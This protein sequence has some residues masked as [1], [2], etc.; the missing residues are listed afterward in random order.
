[1]GPAVLQ[2]LIPILVPLGAFAL[3]AVLVGMGDLAKHRAREL[4]HQTIRFMVDKGQPVPPELLNDPAKA[5]P[6]GTDLSRGVKLISL[7]V[8][9]CAFLYLVSERAWSLGLV[10]I[11]LGIGYVVA[12][13]LSPPPSPEPAGTPR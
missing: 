2:S 9:I 7:G 12:H 8:G 3:V 11:A 10:F 1:M 13:K 6:P 5:P 4:R